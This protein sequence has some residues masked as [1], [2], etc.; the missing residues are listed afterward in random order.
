MSMYSK[1]KNKFIKRMQRHRHRMVPF[2]FSNSLFQSGCHRLPSRAPNLVGL[3]GLNSHRHSVHLF[4]LVSY[5]QVTG[6]SG[7]VMS[8]LTVPLPEQHLVHPSFCTWV[9]PYS[10]RNEHSLR[11]VHSLCHLYQPRSFGSFEI[12]VSKK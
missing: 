8:K 12:I 7:L 2:I 11:C 6:Q 4:S 9:G 1:T 5:Q 3:G 10:R